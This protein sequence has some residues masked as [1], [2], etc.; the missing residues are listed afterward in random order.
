MFKSIITFISGAIVGG[1]AACFVA[2][3]KLKEKDSEI[4]EMRQYYIDRRK[5]DEEDRKKFEESKEQ[6]A[7]I[8]ESSEYE[9]EEDYGEEEENLEEMEEIILNNGYSANTKPKPP[10][11]EII[12]IEEYDNNFDTTNIDQ[13]TLT[14]YA[15]DVLVDRDGFEVDIQETVG[16]D[17]LDA[18][19]KSK[20][21]IVC[22]RNNAINVE[23]EV[24]LDL[25]NHD[26]EPEAID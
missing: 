5:K 11:F 13:I 24:F 20:E 7:D 12:S 4:S 9:N 14:Y 10:K 21:G 15:D 6:S 3:K 17:A 26:Y 8:L 18:L 1:V 25:E 22:V 16:Y 2:R 23:F 19:R